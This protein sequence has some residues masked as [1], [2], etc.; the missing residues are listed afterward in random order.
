MNPKIVL[1][2]VGGAAVAAVLSVMIFKSQDAP[3]P[4]A[5]EAA[6]A[7]APVSTESEV[8]KESAVAQESAAEEPKAVAAVAAPRGGFE[9]KKA[10]AAPVAAAAKGAPA[11]AVEPPR[12]EAPK[13]VAAA[14]PEPIT[15][16]PFRSPEAEKQ[17]E[18]ARAEL[19][20]PEPPKA[21]ER[22]P[23]TVTLAAGTSIV[24]R[25][26]STLSSDKNESGDTFTG[27]L[28]QPI[29][30][31]DMVIAERGARVQGKVVSAEK[32][33][34]V[35]GTSQLSIELT[36]LKTS[37]GQTVAI[38]TDP[39]LREGEKSTKSDAAKV[40]IG[41]A[42]GAAIGAIAGGGKGAGVGAATGAGAGTGVVLATRG[43][44]VQIDVETKVPFRLATAVSI[45]EKIR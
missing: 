3:A 27:T 36:S 24:V 29:V 16:P 5:E 32:A 15:L 31:N 9:R 43:K 42:I 44:P 6:V 12:S 30:V 10:K 38:T 1:A 20:K 2:F 40:G 35:K 21:P 8:A 17:P 13:E 26:N 11:A 37:D 41:A 33:G 4:K 28:D 39:F 45:T 7:A 25:L 22:K 14:K 18:P 23:E 34:R 19:A